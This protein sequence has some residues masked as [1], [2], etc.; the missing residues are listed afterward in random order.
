MSEQKLNELT[1][2]VK[3]YS[4]TGEILENCLEKELRQI[5]LMYENDLENFNLIRLACKKT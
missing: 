3:N 4:N 2:D 5:D 1:S